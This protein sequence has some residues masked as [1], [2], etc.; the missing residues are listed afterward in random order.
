M[1]QTGTNI[2]PSAVEQTGTAIQRPALEQ[3]R[4]DIHPSAMH[5]KK[6]HSIIFKI[7]KFTLSVL[8]FCMSEPGKKNSLVHP[9][10]I[11]KILFSSLGGEIYFKKS[12]IS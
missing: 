7:G 6:Y 1:E 3:T 8:V 2:N 10:N 11:L 12:L 9:G 4:A 5:C